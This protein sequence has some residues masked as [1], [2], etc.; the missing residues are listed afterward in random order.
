MKIE[1]NG[2][3]IS[4]ILDWEKYIFSSKKKKHW[5]VGRSA[6][7]LADFIIHKKGENFIKDEVSKIIKEDLCFDKAEPEFEVRFDK[8][9]H[10]REHDLAIWGKTT[11]GKS[12]FIGVEAKVDEPFGES[13][14]ETYFDAKIEEL[15]GE[16]TNIPKRIEELLKRNFKTLTRKLFDLPYQLLYSTVG[17]TTEK[18]D[19]HVLFVLVFKT[20]IADLSKIKANKKDYSKFFNS[21]KASV[22]KKNTDYKTNIDGQELFVIYRDV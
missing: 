19:I 16:K 15:K 18:A 5:K 11:S 9:G 17:T 12:I 4:N 6:Y 3:T 13:I 2:K 21:M 10:G 8:Y 22:I 7:S 1:Y 20:S 14:L